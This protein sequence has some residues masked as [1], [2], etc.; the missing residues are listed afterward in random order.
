MKNIALSLIILQLFS[1]ISPVFADET[2][3]SDKKKFIVTAYYSPLPNQSFYLKGSYEADIRLNGNGTHGASGKEVY[4]GMLAGPK[5]YAFGTKVYLEGL[6]VG[7][8]DDRGGAIVSSGS[9]GYDA[10]RLDIWMGQ[11]EEGLRRALSWGK[12]SV[13]GKIVDPDKE[14]EQEAIDFSRV[15]VAK[16]DAKAYKQQQG[17]SEQETEKNSIFSST[18]NKNTDPEKIKELQIILSRLS[19]YNGDIDGKYSKNIENAIYDFQIE[20]QLVV[21]RKNLGAGYYGAKTRTK[22]QE[23][24]ALYTEN[25]KKRVAEEARLALEKAAEVARLAKIKTEQEKQAA[26]QKAEVALFI[27]NLGT[28]E[29]NEVGTHV[30]NLQQSLKSLG[31]FTQKD[32]AIFG[33]N[34]RAALV[35]YQTDRDISPEESGKLGKATK[36]ALYKDLLALKSKTTGG[37]AW[38]NK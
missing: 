36:E 8:V 28:P 31:Y 13:T 21:S 29:M 25:E 11:G 19:Y 27:Q 16:I 33:K 6:G 18:V 22:L 12:R 17:Q 5:T 1:L 10:D 32:T 26:A 23:I 4:P 7:T 2:T 15:K 24:Y 30:R 37:L 9:R 20:N 14:A 35:A 3:P 38:N 34:T